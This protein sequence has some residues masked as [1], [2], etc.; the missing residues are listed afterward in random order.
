MTRLRQMGAGVLLLGGAIA[1]V[2]LTREAGLSVVLATLLRSGRWLP[3]LALLE[4]GGVLADALAARSLHGE[5][6]A[7][8]R[9]GVW[10]RAGLVAYAAAQALPGGR[11]L[12][13]VLR[14]AT[15]AEPLGAKRSAVGAFV[16]QGAHVLS[17][18]L[19][20]LLAACL[21]D[22]QPILRGLALGISAW[23]L[24]LGLVLV[25]APRFER[26][27]SWLA[28]RAGMGSLFDD[29]PGTSLGASLVMRSLAWACVARAVHV[30]Q[31]GAVVA[32]VLGEARLEHAFAAEA[33]QLVAASLGDAVP[34]QA[35]VLEGAFRS[36]SSAIA[37][38]PAMASEAL[39]MALLLRVTRL[40]LAGGCAL[41]YALGPRRSPVAVSV[42]ATLWLAALSLS[43]AHA[44]AQRAPHL[45][46]H[47]RLVGQVEPT[48]A[49]YLLSVG[50]RVSFDDGEPLSAG[51]HL[52]A[53]AIAYLSPVYAMTGG[54]LEVSPL[55]FLVFRAEVSSLALW[56]IGV[57][58]AGFYPVEGD[59]ADIRSNSLPGASGQ[60]A[61]GV[62][63]QLSMILQLAF[64]LGP[65]RPIVWSQL[66]GE[67]ERLGEQG[68]HFSPRYGAILA[69]EEW[70]V[71]S[72]SLLLLEISILEGVGLRLG[73]Y[74]DLRA[75][76][77]SG[78]LSHVLGPILMVSLTR[79]DPSVPEALVFLRAGAHLDE[80]VRAGGWTGLL[81]LL[82]THDLGA[83]P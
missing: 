60:A 6:G 4:L 10:L 51:T 81:G 65:L 1:V 26:V 42:A 58:G 76:P 63:V 72:S 19:A 43:P 2:L 67:Y 17:C 21:L 47:Q 31:A 45:F 5:K 15:L 71:A 41:L 8:V 52:E 44:D 49:E 40:A 16:L 83:L 18:A 56:P 30:A 66:T 23:T 68:F 75:I 11:A 77:R 35:G 74:D 37:S 57:D 39:A 55:A 62:N 25:S 48:G 70:M 61:M 46:A 64:D 79:L 32:C 50:G 34:G 69:R 13:E 80:T 38:G 29:G 82:V 9:S 3:L 28:R 36:F 22:S 14:A 54:Y 73:A 24:V 78:A 12:G 20:A 53:G 27:L 7:H 33:I 59:A